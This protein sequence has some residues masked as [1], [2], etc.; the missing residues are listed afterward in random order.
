MGREMRIKRDKWTV[1][2]IIYEEL[3]MLV[4]CPVQQPSLNLKRQQKIRK[5]ANV[6]LTE[7]KILG[8]TGR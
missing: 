2:G 7:H 5:I 3:I 4:Q 1:L 8:Y 6:K